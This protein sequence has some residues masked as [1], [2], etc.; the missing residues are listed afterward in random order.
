MEF[1]RSQVDEDLS[2]KKMAELSGLSVAHF[3]YMFVSRL[4]KAPTDLCCDNK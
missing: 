1:V 4:E 2:L 3:S